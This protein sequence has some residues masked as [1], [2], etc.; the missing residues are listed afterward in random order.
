VTSASRRLR[1]SGLVV[2]GRC[3]RWWLYQLPL[4]AELMRAVAELT[5]GHGCV[6]C[7]ADRLDD[8]TVPSEETPASAN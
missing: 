8:Q 7:L 2:I 5:V 3:G 1:P 4:S 6:Y